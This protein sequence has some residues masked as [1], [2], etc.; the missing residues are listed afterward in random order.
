MG[1]AHSLTVF[2][3]VGG[4]VFP[5]GIAYQPYPGDSFPEDD[6]NTTHANAATGIEIH[7]RGRLFVADE[8]TQV[9]EIHDAASR[10]F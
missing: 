9:V 5:Q 1:N 10:V 3:I 2:M 4:Q 8:R 7:R 6:I